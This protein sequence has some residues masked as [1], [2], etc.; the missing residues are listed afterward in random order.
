MN[1][2]RPQV[3]AQNHSLGP[4]EILAWLRDPAAPPSVPMPIMR[5]L[6]TAPGEEE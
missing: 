5:V 4:V 2:D 6:D 3:P 1:P